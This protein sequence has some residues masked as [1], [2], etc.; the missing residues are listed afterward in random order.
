MVFPNGLFSNIIKT[1]CSFCVS[2]QPF[3]MIGLS[4][5]SYSLFHP[6]IATIFSLVNMQVE[7]NIQI[8]KSLFLHMHFLFQNQEKCFQKFPVELLVLWARIGSYTPF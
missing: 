1:P 3:V 6:K 7:G 4:S 5:E 8:Q 2:A